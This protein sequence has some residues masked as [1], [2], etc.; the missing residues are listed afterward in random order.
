MR[1]CVQCHQPI[2]AGQAIWNL[3]ISDG[4]C[5]SPACV[6]QK[7]KHHAQA[8]TPEQEIYVAHSLSLAMLTPLEYQAQRIAPPD[9]RPIRVTPPP[10]SE[11]HSDEPS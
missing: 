6:Q 5:C 1:T 10:E 11:N 7:L 2:P 3:A 4:P 8:L 9:A